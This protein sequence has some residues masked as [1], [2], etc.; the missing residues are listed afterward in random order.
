MQNNKKSLKLINELLSNFRQIRRWYDPEKANKIIGVSCLLANIEALDDM[1]GRD[2]FLEDFFE[3]RDHETYEGDAEKCEKTNE[4]SDDFEVEYILPI[5]LSKRFL[6][7]SIK[8]FN[9][10]LN[11]FTNPNERFNKNLLPRT[12]QTLEDSLT[13]LSLDGKIDWINKNG[14][15]SFYIGVKE[16]YIHHSEL[17]RR[18]ESLIEN[19]RESINSKQA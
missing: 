16:G 3:V 9:I 10:L 8:R 5:N 1:K 19:Y 4:E 15:Y 14:I 11:K 12:I 18:V 2:I 13:S 7:K 17:G 6:L